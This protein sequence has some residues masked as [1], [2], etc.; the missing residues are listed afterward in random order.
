[1]LLESKI[2]GKLVRKVNWSGA[3]KWYTNGNDGAVGA[4]GPTRDSRFNW[5][6]WGS[7]SIG[8]TGATVDRTTGPHKELLAQME[9]TVKWVQLV[10]LV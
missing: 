7:R 8:L 1:V 2:Q 4:A 5:S 6:Y 3:N 9:Q 10:Q